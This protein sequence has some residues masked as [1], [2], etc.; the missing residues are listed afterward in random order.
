MGSNN[1]AILDGVSIF[2]LIAAVI[3][4][5][6]TIFMA[7]TGGGNDAEALAIPT[8]FII[9]SPTDIPPTLTYTP[10]RTPTETLT[11]TATYT[12]S[13]T[14]TDSPTETQTPTQIPSPTITSTP[15]I[16]LTPD[17]T[18]TPTIEPTPTG[19]T[20]TPPPPLPFAAPDTIQFTRNFA[21]TQGCAWQGIG[22]QVLALGGGSFT[23]PLQVHVYTNGQDF[24]RVFTGSNSAYG[25]SGF[26]VRVANAITTDTY[27]VQLESRNGVPVSTEVQITFPGDCEQNVA[28]INFE[29]VRS[30]NP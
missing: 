30:L 12:P 17:V 5:L 6:V 27:F 11:P 15:T 29:Q 13:S 18:E 19:P 23:N 9:P 7:L 24:G 14:P 22:G 4:I 1:D 10:T 2:F 25:A 20:S 3:A 26:E 28:L 16:T 21:N 8:E